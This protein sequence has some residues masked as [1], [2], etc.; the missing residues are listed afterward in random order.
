[1]VLIEVKCNNFVLKIKF[2]RI[3][4]SNEKGLQRAVEVSWLEFSNI[5]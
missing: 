4:S 1:M 2:D 3:V 5:L